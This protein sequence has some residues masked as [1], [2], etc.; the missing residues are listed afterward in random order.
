MKIKEYSEKYEVQMESFSL[1]WGEFDEA[2]I[3]SCWVAL[4]SDRV[5]GFQSINADGHCV[6][7][8]VLPE[9]QGQGIATALVQYTGCDRPERNECPEFW[10]K[11]EEA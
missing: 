2:G 10:A 3:E 8:E 4:D 11:F 7:I 1:W 6:A 5:V 9:L